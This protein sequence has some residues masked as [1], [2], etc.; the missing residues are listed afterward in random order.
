[1]K[2]ILM[3]TLFAFL[4]LNVKGQDAE[5]V[6]LYNPKENAEKNIEKAKAI[7]KANKKHIFIQGGGNWCGW[8]I[9][10]HNFIKEDEEL[11]AAF[12]EKFVAVKLNYSPENKNEALFKKYGNAQRFGFP[13]FIILDDN[14]ERIHTQNSA[15]LEE[16][17]GYNKAKVLGFLNNWSYEAI[18]QE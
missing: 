15:L 8:C 7:A 3:F 18:R 11:K 5:K 14:G 1:M 9:K 4:S 16:G 2:Y 12:E 13:V 6:K 10:F 17:K